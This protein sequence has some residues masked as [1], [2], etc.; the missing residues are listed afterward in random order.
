MLAGALAAA[1]ALPAPLVPDPGAIAAPPPEP[2]L[3]ARVPA[4]HTGYSNASLAKLF[5]RLT[6][7][8]E[9]GGQRPHLVRM[10]EPVVVGLEG[11]GAS[12]FA[13]F[14]EGYLGWLAA[15]TGIDIHTGGPARALHLRLVDGAEFARAL[16]A[17]ACVLVPGDPGWDAF[18]RD[19]ARFGGEAMLRMH[20][21]PEA[22]VFVPD[23]A[24]PAHVRRC[25]IEEIA[26]ALGPL[27]DLSGLGPSIFND[28][29]GHVW[30]TRLDLM[31]LRVLYAPELATGL[32]RAE[33]E[34][35]A[36][37]ALDRINPAGLS[38]P[39]LPAVEAASVP[40][41]ERLAARVTRRGL[42]PET[43]LEA[44]E[45]ALEHAEAA[46]PGTVWHCR[47]LVLAGQAGRGPAPDRARDRLERAE[48]LCAA[49]H[50][51]DDPRIAQIRLLRAGL[52]MAQGEAEAALAAMD[53]LEAPLAG[54][55]LDEALA[56]YYALRTQAL[57]LLGRSAEGRRA[58]AL[59]RDW[60]GYA[61]GR[62]AAVRLD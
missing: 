30:P 14:L 32:G 18:R 22:T 15:E 1:C 37:A 25:L 43:R 31:M 11:P 27:N 8:T 60:G 54:H 38:A 44:A 41:W 4:G 59:A 7:D 53:G 26:Q 58:S 35:R 29:F 56:A 50:G 13:P 10:E 23:D 28:D 49:V 36:R 55:G 2:A 20:R 19:P 39:P 40:A 42:R 46:L 21:L 33:T 3:L 16:P 34:R 5:V 6:H 47:S 52:E 9:W 17:A 24:I 61:L 57:A 48:R 12:A 62:A 45:I 51:A